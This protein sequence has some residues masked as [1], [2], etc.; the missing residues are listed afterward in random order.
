[1]DWPPSSRRSSTTRREQN[2][3]LLGAL[4]SG[5]VI[6]VAL[7][8]LLLSRANPESGARLR[9]TAID[10]VAPVWSVVR[11]PFDWIGSGFNFAGDYI[12]A[13]SRNRDLEK[14]VVAQASALQVQ[15][16]TQVE[17]RQLRALLNAVTPAHKVVASARIA[18]A[19]GGGVVRSAIVSAGSANGVAIGMPV[20]VAA[21]L[22]GR[23]IDVGSSASRVLLLTDANS[24]IPVTIVRTGQSALVVGAGAALVEVR[25]RVGVEVPL[26]AGDRLV[27]SGDGGVFAPGIPVAVIVDG[28][29][30]PA[31]ARPAVNV[32]GLGMVLIES[33]FMPLPATIPVTE[34][35]VAIP[36]E[37]GGGRAKPSIITATPRAVASALPPPVEA[38]APTAGTTRPVTPS[39]TYHPKAMRLPSVA[40]VL[41]ATDSPRTTPPESPP[42]ATPQ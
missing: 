26:V 31:L 14:R 32:A 1:M 13:A 4:A 34:N 9:G 7:V 37:A 25:E 23:T 35:A 16:A 28:S 39:L 17:N 10:L 18:G 41:S 19:S 12:G 42:A 30:E 38:P 3:A 20:R 15:A 29:H 11:I 22:V 40:P 24:R 33:A 6:A 2:L 21:G 27:T 36:R 5:A 8:L